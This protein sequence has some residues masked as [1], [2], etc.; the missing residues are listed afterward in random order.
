MDNPLKNSSHAL[1]VRHYIL[2][3]IEQK[4]L[5]YQSKL[6]A[7]RMLC[8]RFNITR[9][10]LRQALS[11]LES[12]GLIYRIHHKGWFVS[13]PRI[14]Y[15]PTIN[16]SFTELVLKQNSEPLNR[17]LSTN[18]IP[19]SQW[20]KK[21]FQLSEDKTKIYCIRRLR[22]V[23][24][25][26]VMVEHLYLNA[27]YCKGLLDVQLEQSVTEIL[28]SQY[29]VIITRSSIRLH[30][31]ALSAEQAEALNVATGTSAIYVIRT[32]YDQYDN[33]VEID[34]EFWRND[35]I[36]ITT[37]S[38]IEL[39]TTPTANTLDSGLNQLAK[40]YS[41]LVRHYEQKTGVL[42]EEF[43]RYRSQ[44]KQKIAE[45]NTRLKNLEANS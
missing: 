22:S 37:S 8:T 33:I 19:A 39:S 42:S 41:Q 40:E 10:T 6:P 11:Q 32:S 7:E 44:S 18:S 29:N 3:L 23:D 31:T 36:E 25:R 13:P 34:Q 45:L 14:L 9:I 15:D 30:S 24:G 2:R 5:D 20:L 1:L 35:A 21:L 26:A 4:Q 16:L 28:K 17:I 12:E 43:E 27:L 38:Q